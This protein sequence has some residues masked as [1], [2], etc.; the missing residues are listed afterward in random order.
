M[1]CRDH[2]WPALV[3]CVCIESIDTIPYSVKSSTEYIQHN[4]H[5]ICFSF[6]YS[7]I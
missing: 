7:D 2:A 1:T 4:M 5:V 3:Q 6:F